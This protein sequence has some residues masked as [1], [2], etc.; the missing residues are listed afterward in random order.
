M[1]V[2]NRTK[3]FLTVPL[4][5]ANGTK[6]SINIQPMGRVTLPEGAEVDPSKAAAYKTRIKVFDNVVPPSVVTTSTG[7]T[8]SESST[9]N[10]VLVTESTPK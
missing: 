9:G 6:D 3:D 4:I 1:K 8:A 2:I 5:L 7:G 10:S